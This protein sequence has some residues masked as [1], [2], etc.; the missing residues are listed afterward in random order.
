VVEGSIP[1]KDDGVY[2]ELAGRAAIQV[3]RE[4]AAK[5]AAVIAMGSCASWGGIPSA[6][7]NPTG[8]VGVDAVVSGKPIVN[9]PGCPPNPYNL[10]AVVD[11]EVDLLDCWRPTRAPV[12]AKGGNLI[13]FAETRAHRGIRSST[14]VGDRVARKCYFQPAPLDL[15]FR[16]SSSGGG[17]PGRL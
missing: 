10:L 14:L 16:A 13:Q 1:A 6:D 17:L 2:M 9:L 7:P 5:S 4:V 12:C 8:A 11:T 15:F 3:L